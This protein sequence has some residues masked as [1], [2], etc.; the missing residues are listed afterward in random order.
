M[1]LFGAPPYALLPADD[2]LAK[3]RSVSFA[4]LSERPM[5]MLDLPRTRD[6]FTGRRQVAT[7]VDTLADDDC[8]PVDVTLGHGVSKRTLLVAVDKGRH[9]R[10]MMLP[11]SHCANSIS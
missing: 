2:P 11:S 8:R 6:Y 4:D 7:K 9:C 10:I 5:I 3:S 1:P